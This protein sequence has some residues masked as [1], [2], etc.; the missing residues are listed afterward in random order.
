MSK[1]LE[2]MGHKKRQE[3]SLKTARRVA[4]QSEFRELPSI[5]KGARIMTQGGVGWNATATVCG[6][7]IPAMQRAKKALLDGRP[8][9]RKGRPPLTTEAE[10][11]E[12]VFRICEAGDRR[13]AAGFQEVIIIV[14]TLVTR[15]CHCMCA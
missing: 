2:Q 15:L 6:A 9:G 13:K 8:I 14:S 11:D 3:D 1:P 12:I 10:E 7:K 5:E 4:L